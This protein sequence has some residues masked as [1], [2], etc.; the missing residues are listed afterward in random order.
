MFLPPVAAAEEAALSYYDCHVVAGSLGVRVSF[1]DGILYV[2]PRGTENIRNWL[3]DFRAKL[4]RV[5]RN[6]VAVTVEEGFAE[7]WDALL[8]PV[9]EY[10]LNFRNTPI[11]IPAH[12]LGCPIGRQLGAFLVEKGFIV[13]GALFLESPMTGAIDFENYYA[14]KKIPTLYVRH[15]EDCV[16]V[17]PGAALGYVF[18]GSVEGGGET[19]IL[20]EY[21]NARM[22]QP[23]AAEFNVIERMADTCRDHGVGR[24]LRAYRLY[25]HGREVAGLDKA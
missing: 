21:G 18:P 11:F 20:D 25:H 14:S 5:T 24:V 22:A 3:L 10:L 17:L 13:V 4:I 7:A 1:R 6:G 8:N 23:L 12:S 19:L 16:P 15:G 9:G 2:S